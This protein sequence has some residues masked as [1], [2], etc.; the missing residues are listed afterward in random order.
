MVSSI[1]SGVG[2]VGMMPKP[3]SKEEA[4]KKA[5]ADGDG[6]INKTELDDVVLHIQEMSGESI[7]TEAL[8]SEYDA[9]GDGAL[10]QTEMDKAMQSLM[11]N[12][13][14]PMPPM[15]ENATGLTDTEDEETEDTQTTLLE[16]LL[17]Q[18]TANS[19]DTTTQSLVDTKV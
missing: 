16:T 7:D 14:P 6:V 11:K 2:S 12:A 4:F 13:K 18:Y 9:D 8:L 5:D 1:G 3:P 10:D 19:K 17:S 15:A